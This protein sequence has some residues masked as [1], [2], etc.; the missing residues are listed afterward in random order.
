MPSTSDEAV[1]QQSFDASLILS[2][3]RD[4]DPDGFTHWTVFD[5]LQEGLDSGRWVAFIAFKSG[6][7]IGAILLETEE[8]GRLWIDLLIVSKKH[9]GMHVGRSLV[10]HAVTYGMEHDHRV[11]FVDVDYDNTL[12]LQ[13]YLALGF[14]NAGIVTNYYSDGSGAVFLTR[15]L[16]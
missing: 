11:L 12:A 6:L 10:E 3:A 14:T 1:I 7:P 5:N 2:L 16:S 8:E 13:F 15:P 9:R 4:N